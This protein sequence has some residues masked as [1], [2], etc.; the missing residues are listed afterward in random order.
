MVRPVST[1]GVVERSYVLSDE[2]RSG[3]FRRE[4]VDRAVTYLDWAVDD[5]PLRDHLQ[6]GVAD[7]TTFVTALQNEEARPVAG[8]TVIKALLGKLERPDDEAVMPDGRVALIQCWC[9]DL[10]CSTL[11]AEVVAADDVVEW[12][13]VS[14]Q[15]AYEPID[16]GYA[17]FDPPTFRFDRAQYTAELQRLIELERST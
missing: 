11:T 4:Q 3:W 14:W 16:L 1:L 5:V 10:N 2:V 6:A 13:D 12:R 9:F 15:V 8:R 7:L 17:D